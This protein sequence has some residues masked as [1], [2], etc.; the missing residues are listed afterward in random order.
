M[1]PFTIGKVAKATG[2]GV[3]TI[4]FYERR[5]LV[6][7]PKRPDTGGV[8]DYDADTVARLRFIR[9]AKEVGFSLAEIAELLA[10]R[11][12]GV[13]GCGTVRARAIS[14]RRDIEDRLVKLREICR[15]LDDLIAGCP[16]EGHLSECT[17]LEAMESDFR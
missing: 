2:V 10:L 3:E 13:A 15:L 6:V 14:K 7:Q 4:R 17:I 5:G 1:K 12:D 11:H 8:R 9:Q 16:G